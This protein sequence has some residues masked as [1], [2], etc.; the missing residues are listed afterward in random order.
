M[1]PFMPFVTE[2]LWGETGKTGPARERL[3]ALS[4]W[5]MLT[6]LGDTAAEAEMNWLIDVVSGIRS[7]RTEMN[8]PAAAKIPLLIIGAGEETGTRVE[9]QLQPLTRMAR[10]SEVTYGSDVPKGS[11]QIVIGEATFVLPLT[12]IIDLDAERVRLKREIAK[13][14]V[15]IGKIDKKLDNEQFVSKAPPEVIEEQRERRAEAVARLERLKAALAR[16]S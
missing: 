10:L 9:S 4:E 8:V 14:E 11:A 5:P 6:G 1:H 15:E 16:L 12:G 3:L 13:E 2:E 7:V